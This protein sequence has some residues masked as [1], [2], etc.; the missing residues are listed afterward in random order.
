MLISPESLAVLGG[1][2]ALAGGIAGSSIGVGW[3]G[4]PA[5]AALA[6]DPGQLKNV[7]ILVSLP[8][9]Q[10]FYALIILILIITTVVPNI[11]AMPDP[12][13]AGF[14]VFACGLISSSAELWSAAYQG[15]ICGSG[16]SLLVKTKGQILANSIMLA[17]FV[18]LLGVLGMVFTI[19]AFSM[20]GL[21]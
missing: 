4:G 17:V 9:T 2:V 19:M 14:A 13:G 18:E 16:I 20:L 11:S 10:T 12:R 8:L 1:A 7:L 3:A 5:C 6:E 21:F 15:A